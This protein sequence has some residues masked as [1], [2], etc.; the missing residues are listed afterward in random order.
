MSFLDVIEKDTTDENEA[1]KIV[2]LVRILS[3]VLSIFSLC[4]IIV[5]SI[6]DS[7]FGVISGAVSVIIGIVVL[8]ATYNIGRM[9]SV[10]CFLIWTLL[11]VI[12]NLQLYGWFCGAQTFLLVMIM[13]FYFAS[14][15]NPGKKTIFSVGIFIV[16]MLLFFEYNEKTALITLSAD[17]KLMVRALFM[18]TLIICTSMVAYLFSRDSQSMESKMIEYNKMLKEKA[19][20]DP[21][22]GLLNRG[23]AMERLVTLASRLNNE[24]FSICICDIDFFK[25]VND[26]YGHNMGDQVL[27]K[28]G[29][30][31]KQQMKGIGAAARWGGEEFLL[32]FPRVNGDDALQIVYDIQSKIRN[33]RIPCENGIITVTMTFGLTEYDFNAEL[34]YNIKEADN[35]LYI[36]KDSGRNKVVY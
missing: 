30:V 9:A 31:L 17:V 18:G 19:S 23:A 5:S 24:C 1:N 8:M 4:S 16:Y 28:I 14:Y 20:R 6:W 36:G 7:R 27:I 33:I 12:I 15:A 11:W 35:K 29:D 10:N 3:I 22:T 13:M 2:V 25:N 34:D 32:I 21:L 26:T